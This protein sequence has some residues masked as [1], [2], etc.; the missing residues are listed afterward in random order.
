MTTRRDTVLSTASGPR[1][2]PAQSTTAWASA[3]SGKQKAPAGDQSGTDTDSVEQQEGRS[4]VYHPPVRLGA[5]SKTLQRCLT[6][7]ECYLGDGCS[8]C[9]AGDG[10]RSRK[11]NQRQR[12]AKYKKEQEQRRAAD[13]RALI[14]PPS[15]HDEPGPAMP[16]QHAEASNAAKLAEVPTMAESASAASAGPAAVSADMSAAVGTPS[17]GAGAPSEMAAVPEPR[18]AVA[19]PDPRADAAGSGLPDATGAPTPVERGEV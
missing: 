14:A 11:T 17:D 15:G 8:C 16:T 7:F 18:P 5:H 10:A 3:R 13:L 1:P 12:K 6:P 19:R 2:E 9:V 4:E